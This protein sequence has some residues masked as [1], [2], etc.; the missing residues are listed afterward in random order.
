MEDICRGRHKDG[1]AGSFA[2][3]FYDFLDTGIR[4]ILKDKGVFAKLDRLSGDHLAIFYFHASSYQG[5]QRFNSAF[6]SALGLK[7]SIHLPCVVFFKLGE[8]GFTDVAVATLDNTDLIHGFHELY[9]I[10]ERYLAAQS[11][12]SPAGLKFVRWDKAT[13]QSIS[14]EALR[15]AFKIFLN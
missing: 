7:E 6:L 2:F 12:K 9:G 14:L 8:S 3:I 10:I 5:T 4:K 11:L 13:V 1:K 15:I